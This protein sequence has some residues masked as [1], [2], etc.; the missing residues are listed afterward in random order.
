MK[1]TYFNEREFER[2]CPCS[3]QLISYVDSLVPK[4]LTK[5]FN[6]ANQYDNNENIYTAIYDIFDTTK[7]NRVKVFSLEV[8]CDISDRNNYQFSHTKEIYNP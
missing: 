3:S 1:H 7:V 2:R 5:D 4:N 6:G 8:K